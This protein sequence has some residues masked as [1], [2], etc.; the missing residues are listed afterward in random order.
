MATANGHAGTAGP[1]C[2]LAS[3][4]A[5]LHGAAAT[6]LHSVA[7]PMHFVKTA[8]SDTDGM[9]LSMWLGRKLKLL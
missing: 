1:V 6:S 2:L 8:V 7:S 4:A 3:T 9:A 5:F